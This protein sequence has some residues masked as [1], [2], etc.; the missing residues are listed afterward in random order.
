V[1]QVVCYKGSNI[2]FQIAKRIVDIKYISLVNL[3]MDRPVVTEL[4]QKEMNVEMVNVELAKILDIA[5]RKK[6]F[7]DY[8]E[9][10]QILG[11][12]GASENAAELMLNQLNS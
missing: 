6:I 8:K 12:A 1:P 10:R 5:N 9:L 4:I 7:S 3:I 11:G 2:S